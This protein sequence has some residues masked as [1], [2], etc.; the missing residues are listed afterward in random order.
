MSGFEFCRTIHQFSDL[1]VIM[2]T[3]VN[4]ENTVIEGLEEHAED[5]IIKPFNP[6]ELVARINRVLQRMGSNV[7]DEHVL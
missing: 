3:A 2:L 1:P 7:R 5:Y 6:G 4:E